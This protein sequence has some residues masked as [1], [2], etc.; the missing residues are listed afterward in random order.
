MSEA[1][2]IM[3][4]QPAATKRYS[5][6]RYTFKFQDDLGIKKIIHYQETLLWQNDDPTHNDIRLFK[7]QINKRLE[8]LFDTDRYLNLSTRPS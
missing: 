6:I 1:H 5:D 7:E 8:Q 3:K 4:D 2:A